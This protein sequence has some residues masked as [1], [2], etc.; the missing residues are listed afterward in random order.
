MA[1]LV[2]FRQ[3]DPLFAIDL[4]DPTAPTVLGSLE[5]PGFSEYIHPIDTTHLV[6]IGR[7][8]GVA[9]Q[10]F[11]VTSPTAP[12]LAD[13]FVFTADGYTEAA[14]SQK[15]FT[16]FPSRHVLAFLFAGYASCGPGACDMRSTLELFRVDASSITHLGSIDH[17]GLFAS[18]PTGYCGGYYG[19]QVR[20]GLFMDD[21]V[22]AVSYAG[23]TANALTDL[24]T[25][26]NSLSLA[27]PETAFSPCIA[28]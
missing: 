15:A 1:Y 23:V 21:V 17:S 2:T 16:Y 27:P 8:Q 4:S 6:T 26:L 11:D 10:L 3:V 28:W 9:V 25:S 14:Q 7:D 18:A 19:A 20:R 12:L 24:A 13:K 5:I 22:Y